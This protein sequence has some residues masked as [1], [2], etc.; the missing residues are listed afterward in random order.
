MSLFIIPR[1]WRGALDTT[2]CDT[3]CQWLATSRWFSP[4]SPTN[5]IDCHDITDILLKVAWNTIKQTKQNFIHNNCVIYNKLNYRFLF[6]IKHLRET[7]N[8]HINLLVIVVKNIPHEFLLRL[9]SLLW[10]YSWCYYLYKKK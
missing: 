2:I 1:S 3:V 4:I 8:L 5:K 9:D 6:F 7:F 10:F